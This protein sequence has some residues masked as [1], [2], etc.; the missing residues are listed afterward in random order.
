MRDPSRLII[1]SEPFTICQIGHEWLNKFLRLATDHRNEPVALLHSLHLLILTQYTGMNTH[2]Q[3]LWFDYRSRIIGE[4]SLM[5]AESR[6]W[7]KALCNVWMYLFFA[8]QIA[9]VVHLNSIGWATWVIWPAVKTYGL[10]VEYCPDCIIQMLICLYSFMKLFHKDYV[11][12]VRRNCTFQWKLQVI[13]ASEE[14]ILMKW[15]CK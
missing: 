7:S 4:A 13:V 2:L 10:S 1:I 6:P 3:L 12:F 11:L 9:L 8:A 14:V 15:F 5:L